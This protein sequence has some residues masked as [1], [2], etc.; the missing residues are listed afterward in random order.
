MALIPADLRNNHWFLLGLLLRLAA[1]LLLVPQIQADW[2][3]PFMVETLAAPSLD[4]WTQFLHHGDHPPEFFYGPVMY[5]FHA[6]FV[7]L[8]MLA[9][10]LAGSGTRLAQI[11]LGLSLLVADYALLLVLRR[12][13]EGA[14]DRVLLAYWF[15][16]LVLFITY[17][18]GDTDVVPT[19]M[20]A[21]TLLLLQRGAPCWAGALLG[22][23]IA[24]K[25]GI[26]A[27]LPFLVVFLWSHRRHRDTL[28]RFLLGSLGVAGLLLLPPLLLSPGL[29]QMLMSNPRLLAANPGM[30]S[31]LDFDIMLGGGQKLYIMP[32]VYLLGLYGAWKVGRMS[33]DLLFT[34]LGVAYLVVLLLTPSAVGW[35]LWVVPFLVAYQMR[36]GERGAALAVAFGLAFILAKLVVTVT[37][38]V[39]LLGLPLGW[40]GW[41]PE[42]AMASLRVTSIT[43]SMLTAIGMVLALTMLR[44]GLEENDFFG[45]SQRPLAIG[46]AGDSGTGKDTLALALAGLFGEGAVTGVSGD[47]YH[48]FERRGKLWQAFTH[49]DPR[50]N[51][52]EAFTRDALSLIAWRPIMCRHYDHATGLFTPPR[53]I[54]ASDV[55]MVT[56]LHALY[57]AAL[58]E[59]LDVAVYLDMDESL[60]RFFKIRR[61]VQQRGHSLDRVLSSIE[62]R[63]PDYEA[64]IRPQREHADVVFSLLPA[65]PDLL[66]DIEQEGPIPLKLRIRMRSAISLDRLA[67]LLIAL[68][69]AQVDVTQAAG[70][71]A[72][73]ELVID[74]SD[75]Q[76]ED[77]Q[78]TAQQLVPHLEELLA[79][80]PAWHPGMTGIMQLITLLQ[81]AELTPKRR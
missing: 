33:F 21:G 18:H 57:P 12:M 37:P 71:N 27:I 30:I 43:A 65:D 51:D 48:L 38:A 75:V 5:L 66:Q 10:H 73:A 26:L 53:R 81:L 36:A 47:D 8:G 23:A 69:G 15:S 2:F 29:H 80:V 55:V 46:I 3:T 31:I 32:I 58:R 20:V 34:V 64:F 44:R 19:L 70:M 35:Y 28:P 7:A 17:W 62:R 61:D 50:A 42:D 13:N 22:L 63:M 16:P 79:R 78:F 74:G 41:M 52:L 40:G 39:P 56:G 25:I 4:P 49:L 24:A 54:Q 1:I 76:A 6:P 11:G 59:R 9:D 77:I 72:M 14:V 60:R 45:L 67:R 68:C